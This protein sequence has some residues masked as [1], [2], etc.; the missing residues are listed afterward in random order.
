MEQVN[1]AIAVAAATVVLLGLVSRRAQTLPVTRPLLAM[2]VGVLVGPQLLGWL[3][4]FA[5]PDDKML[6]KEM[7]RVTLA[8]AV[9]GIALRTPPEDY[10][11]FLRPVAVL[12][13]LGMV[14]MWAVST[15]VG[16]AALALSPLVALAFGAAVA[17]TDPV[18]ASSVVT[19]SAAEDTF[20]DGLRSTLSLESG[21]NDG[22]GYLIVMAPLSVALHEGRALSYWVTDVLVVGVLLAV[23]MGAALGWLTAWL[24]R[25]AHEAGWVENHS[26]LGLTVALSLLT[27]SAAKLAGSDG[28]LAA[29]AAGAAFNLTIDRQDDLEEQNVQETIAK[30]FS[31]PVFLVFGA[32]LPVADWLSLGW[33]SLWTALGVVLLRRPLALLLSGPLLGARLVRRDI[34]F[35]SWFGPIGVAAIY[36]A[37]HIEETLQEPL[38]WHAASLVILLSVVLH[39]LTSGPALR[40]FDALKKRS[41]SAAAP[42]A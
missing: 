9:I 34:V 23:A 14:A 7:A 16:W 18:V 11:R 29:F 32:M 26:L 5:W 36:Y 25:T 15:V 17:P 27:L 24:T 40:L 33:P 35:L 4:P 2:T 41:C 6:L 19:G 1:T 38:V 37:L 39:G 22:L 42:S 12:L 21:A 8:I 20:P 28:I 13:T 10:R 31:L 30:L 3:Q